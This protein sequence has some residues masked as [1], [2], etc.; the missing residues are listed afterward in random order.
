MTGWYSGL[1]LMISFL[2]EW[3][4]RRCDGGEG[5]SDFQGCINGGASLSFPFLE[6]HAFET[7]IFT[8]FSP[9]QRSTAH[10]KTNA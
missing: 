4:W 1:I 3:C 9:V 8:L 10:V 6:D 2:S 7:S 5:C